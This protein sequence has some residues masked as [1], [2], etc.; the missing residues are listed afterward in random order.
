MYIA[1]QA[2][3]AAAAVLYVTDSDGIQPV[4]HRLSLRPIAIRFFAI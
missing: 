3:T 1:L 4:G 2:T